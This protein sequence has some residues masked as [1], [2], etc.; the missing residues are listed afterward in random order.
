MY[1]STKITGVST[2][3]TSVQGSTCSYI[4]LRGMGV[5]RG[6][7]TDVSVG[8]LV[9]LGRTNMYDKYGNT[10]PNRT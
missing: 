4:F 1:F 8:N 3:R 5:H 2:A 7:S 9:V 6:T 10:N